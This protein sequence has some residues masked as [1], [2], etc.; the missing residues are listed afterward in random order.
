MMWVHQEELQVEQIRAYLLHPVGRKRANHSTAPSAIVSGTKIKERED[1]HLHRSESLLSIAKDQVIAFA[2]QMKIDLEVRSPRG[3]RAKWVY[4]VGDGDEDVVEGM[5][6]VE[7]ELD[8]V[9]GGVPR[10]KL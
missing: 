5:L 4:E 8:A 10:G 9:F 1:S 3:G 6:L 7:L 2:K